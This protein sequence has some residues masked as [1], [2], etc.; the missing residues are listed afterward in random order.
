[1]KNREKAMSVVTFSSRLTE[2]GSFTIPP[3][4]VEQLGI[5]PGDEIRVRIEAANGMPDQAELQRRSAK[6]FEED[7]RT[8]REPG[9]PLTD[10]YEAAWAQGVEE[11]AR[12]MGL[13]L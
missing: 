4:A 11:K 3:E 6:L 13:K 7:D 9:K 1:M 12:K 8:I 2:D 10:P 5:H